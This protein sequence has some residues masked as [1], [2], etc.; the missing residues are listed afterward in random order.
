MR[1]QLQI[2]TLVVPSSSI[3]SRQK[4]INQYYSVVNTSKRDGNDAPSV[5]EVTAVQLELEKTKIELEKEKESHRM[6][7]VAQKEYEESTERRIEGYETHIA[8]L[9]EEIEQQA[10]QIESLSRLTR[11]E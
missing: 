6:Y 4:E 10:S 1:L 8:M 7:V 2:A 9:S 5:D 11:C 3:H